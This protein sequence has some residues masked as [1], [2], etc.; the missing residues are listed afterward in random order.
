MDILEKFLHSIAYKFPK[1]YPDASN[2]QDMLLLENELKTIGID[3]NELINTDHYNE[4][5]KERGNI[6]DIVNLN[7]QI[8]GNEYNAEDIKPKII[9]DIKAELNKRLSYLEDLNAIPISFSKAVAYKVLKPILKINNDKH[10]LLLKTEYSSKGGSKLNIGTSYI[11]IVSTNKLITLL[12]IESKSDSDLEDQIISHAKREDKDMQS[13]TILSF[14][15]FEYIIPLGESTQQKEFIDPNTLPYRLKAS[16]RVGSDF[17]HN[18]YGI[19]KVISAASA[20]TRS[21]EPD[22]RG[23]VDWVE[24]DFGKPYVSKGELKKTRIIK[25]VYTTLSPLISK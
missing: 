14:S 8:L 3:L 16:Y 23:I 17:T 10:E 11:A 18:D 24:I 13:V 9:S 15:D 2:K 22:S 6:L 21:G 5:K 7:K 19:G 20:G 25:N 1:G 4:R 12:L